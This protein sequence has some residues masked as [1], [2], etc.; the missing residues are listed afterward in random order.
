MV[1]NL[2]DFML[3]LRRIFCRFLVNYFI[4]QTQTKMASD[5]VAK[6]D[7]LATDIQAIMKEV[8]SQAMNNADFS[9]PDDPG[10]SCR[11]HYALTVSPL[12]DWDQEGEFFRKSGLRHAKF[13]KKLCEAIQVEEIWGRF[14]PWLYRN[15]ESKQLNFLS[16]HQHG[17]GES[18]GAPTREILS[19]FVRDMKTIY[20]LSAGQD[21]DIAYTITIVK[22][23]G[24]ASGLVVNEDKSEDSQQDEDENI[25][26]INHS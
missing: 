17:N 21:Y 8:E 5:L 9:L 20:H 1:A 22:D 25:V 12:L 2:Q 13:I 26:Y 23:Y 19:R 15:E 24:T 4:V 7:S 3:N 18:I 14:F 11:K 6:R 10:K 16:P